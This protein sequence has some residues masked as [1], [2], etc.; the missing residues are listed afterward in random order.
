[1]NFR[2]HWWIVAFFKAIAS[3]HDVLI[4]IFA[5]VFNT[6]LK[7]SSRSFNPWNIFNN[8]KKFQNQMS[9]LRQNVTNV[10]LGL[11]NVCL[12]I[13]AYFSV[14]LSILTRWL[15]TTSILVVIG[16]IY[17]YQFKWSYLKKQKH[18]VIF[19]CIFGIYI[20]FW[21]FWEKKWA[22]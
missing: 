12:S 15:P 19:Y 18:F 8:Q 16:R 3:S 2:E 7:H 21:R 10:L 5:I 13:S 17:R 22:S 9:Q 20:K 1:M 11:W 14:F 4:C 6:L